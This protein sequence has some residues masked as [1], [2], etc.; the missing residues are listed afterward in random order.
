VVFGAGG[1]PGGHPMAFRNAL[2]LRSGPGN[3]SDDSRRKQR[4]LHDAFFGAWVICEFGMSK[5]ASVVI[6]SIR[7]ASLG[8]KICSSAHPL[9]G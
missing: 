6:L 9:P 4:C 7:P 8:L 5:K 2:V 1:P 3:E